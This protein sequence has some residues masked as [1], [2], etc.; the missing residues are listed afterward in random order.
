[1]KK[2][3][4]FCVFPVL[5]LAEIY[6]A[7]LEPFDTYAIK[8]SVSG[9]VITSLKQKEGLISDGSIVVKLD[10]EL[11][12][13]EL[14]NAQEK[15]IFLNNMVALTQKNIVNAKEIAKIKEE[16][17][18]KIKELKTKSKVDKDNEYITLITTQNQVLA[19]EESLENL[20]SQLSDLTFKIALLKDRIEKKS[21]TVAKGFLIYK[22]YTNEHDVVGVGSPLIDAYDV[23]NGKLS[24]FLSKD[25][26]ELAKTGVV[27]IDGQKSDFKVHKIWS[28]ADTQ[29]IS[30]YRCE[31]IVPSPKQFSGLFKVEFKAK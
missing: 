7:K 11:D 9:E 10:D 3:I 12:K 18:N 2:V 24:I 1:M 6:Y 29:N 4:L 15:H 23:K 22:I 21:V 13:K 28:V 5:L 31:I 8:S 14:K 26:V 20:K 27:Y 30:S 16:N 19:L 25:D 17:F